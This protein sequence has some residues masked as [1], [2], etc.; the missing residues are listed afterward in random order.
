MARGTL[1]KVFDKKSQKLLLFLRR[2]LRGQD[3][4]DNYGKS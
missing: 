3:P 1:G 4:K 2:R